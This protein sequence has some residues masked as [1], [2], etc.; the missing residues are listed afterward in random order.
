M[1]RKRYLVREGQLTRLRLK[2]RRLAEDKRHSRK[3]EKIYMF[4]FSDI[5]ILT[6]L[7]NPNTPNGQTRYIVQI[8]PLKISE[9]A[10]RNVPDASDGIG[11]QN[12][13]LLSS[14]ISGT[15][16]LQAS[17]LEEKQL[18]INDFVKENLLGNFFLLKFM[19]FFFFLISK[20]IFYN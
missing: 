2:N 11:A 9:V 13:F 19:L 4:F 18:W 12:V 7:V 1:E 16:V 17:S 5:I 14:R 8:K 20:K 6:K 10:I 3:L 15:L